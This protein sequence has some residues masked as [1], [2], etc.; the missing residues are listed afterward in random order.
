MTAQV[1]TKNPSDFQRDFNARIGNLNCCDRLNSFN[2]EMIKNVRSS[3]DQII[4]K[5]GKL[6]TELMEDNG[7]IVC[8]GSTFSDSPANYTFISEQGCSTIDFFWISENAASLVRDLKA[9]ILLEKSYLLVVF[10]IAI[11]RLKKEKKLKCKFNENRHQV[12]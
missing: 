12:G 10:V 7:L 2:N 5:R 11:N 1:T 3:Y 9:S 6:L 4:N 8:N